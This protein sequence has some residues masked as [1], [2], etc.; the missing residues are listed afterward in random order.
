MGKK[1][2]KKTTKKRLKIQAPAWF[3][4][5]CR[6]PTSCW[7]ICSIEMEPTEMTRKVWRG[8]AELKKIVRKN[9]KFDVENLGISDFLKKKKIFKFFFWKKK[10]NLIP[11]KNYFFQIQRSPVE[12]FCLHCGHR[13]LPTRC[14]IFWRKNWNFA[15]KSAK[16]MNF[17]KFFPR[18]SVKLSIFH[19]K[20]QFSRQKPPKFRHFSSIPTLQC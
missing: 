1:K 10:K 2:L 16:T 9:G 13:I 7:S 18:K 19:W 3:P 11:K 12:Q 14:M 6:F 17:L 20:N 8:G 15:S 4:H 5:A